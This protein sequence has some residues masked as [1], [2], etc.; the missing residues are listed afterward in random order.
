[1]EM[2]MEASMIQSMPTAIQRPGE[3]GI[4]IRAMEAMMAP[5]RKN[6]LRRPSL[7]QVLSLMCPIMG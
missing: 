6:G 7:P 3:L 4:S 2:L 5:T 1:M